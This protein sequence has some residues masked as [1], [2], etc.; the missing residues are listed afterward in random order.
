[1]KNWGQECVSNDFSDHQRSSTMY[2]APLFHLYYAH[3]VF[4]IDL[5]LMSLAIF[6]CFLAWN[7]LEMKLI[8]PLCLKRPSLSPLSSLLIMDLYQLLRIWVRLVQS[9]LE[10][11]FL[12]VVDSVLSPFWFWFWVSSKTFTWFFIR[13]QCQVIRGKDERT[14]AH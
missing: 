14:Y 11:P 12:M 7:Y 10:L 6:C 4:L 5:F 9:S 1:M 13:Q 8:V 2:M 3:P